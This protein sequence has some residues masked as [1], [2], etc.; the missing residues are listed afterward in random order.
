MSINHAILG[1]LSGKPMTGYDL[2]KLIQESSFLYWSGNNNQI[3]KALVEL[4]NEGF[5]TNK[6]H[7][8]GSLPSKKIYTVTPAGLAELRQWVL[9]PPEPPEFKKT[10]LIQL[11]WAD[12]LNTDELNFL[13]AGYEQEVHTQLL[14]LEGQ[15]ARISFGQECNRRGITLW[16]LI[17]SNLVSTYTHEL[18]WLGQLRQ[19][20]GLT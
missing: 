20:L 8:Q 16:K 10:F 2:K 3:Y 18:V 17:H 14:L 12:L 15:A 6:V 19:E 5:V 11:A 4:L 9:S 1:L 13:L 7:H